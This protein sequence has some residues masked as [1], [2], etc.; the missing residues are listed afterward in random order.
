MS[1]KQLIRVKLK[2]TADKWKILKE[3]KRLK[4]LEAWE[5]VYINPE[6]TPQ[7]RQQNYE[8]RQILRKKRTEAPELIHFIKHNRV[9][10]RQRKDDK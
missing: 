5:N 6:L 4:N 9:V 8:L 3:A 7:Q 2:N 1:K 10:S